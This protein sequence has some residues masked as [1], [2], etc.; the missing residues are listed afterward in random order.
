MKFLKFKETDNVWF[1]SDPHFGHKNICLGTSTWE[2]DNRENCRK[3]NTV[4]QMDAMIID[5]INSV[6]GAEDHLICL[7]DWCFTGEQK[8]IEYRNRIVC[9]NLHLVLGNHDQDI[10]EKHNKMLSVFTSIR[11]YLEINMGPHHVIMSHFPI[12]SW[13]RMHRGSF[14]LFG[15]QH[16]NSNVKLRMGKKLDVGLDGNDFMPYHWSD[17]FKLLKDRVITT[18]HHHKDRKVQEL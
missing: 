10:R 11:D 12:E 7:G 17:I 4:D 14:H 13:N 9:Q 8:I 15:H 5:N 1:F 18:D 2:G 6:V 16:S 3:F